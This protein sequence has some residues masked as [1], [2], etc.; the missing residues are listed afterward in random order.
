MP[1]LNADEIRH[2]CA[3]EEI[4]YL[5]LKFFPF[6]VNHT[7]VYLI[8]LTLFRHEYARVE[9]VFLSHEND[10]VPHGEFFRRYPE[11]KSSL[12]TFHRLDYLFSCE[13][14]KYLREEG[15]RYALRFRYLLSLHE[16]VSVESEIGESHEG[17]PDGI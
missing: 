10:D 15:F 12:W 8:H 17:V 6:V 7:G 1:F 16:S 11:G 4:Y 3:L 14:V 2:R 5:F 13:L 9:L